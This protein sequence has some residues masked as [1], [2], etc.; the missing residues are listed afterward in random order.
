MIKLCL[1]FLVVG[2][3]AFFLAFKATLKTRLLI[4]F[5]CSVVPII[6]SFMIILYSGDKAAEDA[7]EYKGP[8][9]NREVDNSG[10]QLKK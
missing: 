7:V 3:V 6:I 10:D 5:L 1:T 8:Q 4:A 9:E 2:V